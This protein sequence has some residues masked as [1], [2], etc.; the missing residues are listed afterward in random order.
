MD[1]RQFVHLFSCQ[2]QKNI[3]AV[4]DERSRGNLDDPGAEAEESS[5][6][7]EKSRHLP[8]EIGF[9]GANITYSDAID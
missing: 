4:V 2:G 9:C 7:D 1:L 5:A 3:V 8:I 6:P